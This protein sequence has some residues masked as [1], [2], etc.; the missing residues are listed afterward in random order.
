RSHPEGLSEYDCL[1]E[2][3]QSGHADFPKVEDHDTL[4]LFQA[5]FLLFHALYQLRDKLWVQ[6]TGHLEIS[7]LQIIL[8]PY[9][10]GMQ[11]IAPRDPLREYYLDLENLHQSG[12]AEIDDML[13]RFWT[14]YAA[15]DELHDALAVLGLKAPV[16]Y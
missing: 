6:R 7:P 3:W 15:H 10:E 16:D 13:V 1:T 14:R 4:Q 5:H 2:I 8:H 12:P 9:H 11:S